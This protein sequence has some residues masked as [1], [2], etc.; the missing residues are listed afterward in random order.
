MSWRKV[1]FLRKYLELI[2]NKYPSSKY[3]ATKN[4]FISTLA[5]NMA[6]RL[7]KMWEA[8]G[9][10]HAIIDNFFVTI[11]LNTFDSILI[12]FLSQHHNQRKIIILCISTLYFKLA[13]SNSFFLNKPWCVFCENT[14]S[15]VTRTCNFYTKFSILIFSFISAC[16]FL[17]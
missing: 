13:I 8:A 11:V 7:L 5:S 17:T 12:H 4:W 6:Q 10:I 16:N 9:I 1:Y 15:Y 2:L 14:N 3:M